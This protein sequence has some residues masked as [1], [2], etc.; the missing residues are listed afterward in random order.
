MLIESHPIL[1]STF[2]GSQS[3]SVIEILIQKIIYCHL[4]FEENVPGSQIEQ[5]VDPVYKRP[6][7]SES[8]D[9][10]LVSK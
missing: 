5:Y 1:K 4:P 7:T 9:S 10:Y 6:N 3:I 2:R 8:Y